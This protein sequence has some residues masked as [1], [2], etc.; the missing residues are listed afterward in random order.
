MKN[1]ILFISNFLVAT[2]FGLDIMGYY[3]LNGVNIISND[4]NRPFIVWVG[5]A[6][7]L[8]SSVVF[9]NEH[10]KAKHTKK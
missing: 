1:I 4:V 10:M 6:T 7:S 3:F 2:I 9:M 8:M 5:F